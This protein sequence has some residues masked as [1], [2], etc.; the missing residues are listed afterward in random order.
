MYILS[1]E[2]PPNFIPVRFERTQSA[3]I[4]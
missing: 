4:Y 1:E 3:L 2:V